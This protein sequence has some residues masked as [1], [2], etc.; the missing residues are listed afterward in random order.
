M[1]NKIARTAL[2]QYALIAVRYNSYLRSFYLKLNRLLKNSD[3]L[4]LPNLFPSLARRFPFHCAPF[5]LTAL[6]ALRS[7]LLKNRRLVRV[8]L[9]D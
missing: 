7:V 2:V 6:T 1:G 5:G 4:P 8:N 3:A 9:L